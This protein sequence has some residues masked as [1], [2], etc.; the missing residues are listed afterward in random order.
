MKKYHFIIFSFFLV[1]FAAITHAK[2]CPDPQTTSLILGG[3]VCTQGL[4][5]CQ[6]CAELVTWRH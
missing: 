6:F 2:S 3:F 5:S 1:Q 4:G